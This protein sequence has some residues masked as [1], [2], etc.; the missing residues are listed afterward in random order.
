MIFCYICDEITCF[1]HN[2]NKMLLVKTAYQQYLCMRIGNQ[3]K[4]WTPHISCNSCLIILQEWLKNK[5]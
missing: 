1:S 5:R 4:S 2:L 3:D